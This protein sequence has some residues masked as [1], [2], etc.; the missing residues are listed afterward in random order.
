VLLLGAI[1][2]AVFVVPG[3]WGIAAVVVAVAYEL[4][5]KVFWFRYSQRE[6]IAVGAEA[7]IGA[8]ARV[9]SDCAPRGLVR[10]RG[11]L[12]RAR[13]AERAF[14]CERVRIGSVGRDL[15]LEVAPER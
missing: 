10:F 3:W 7:M 13:C 4:A 2:L 6:P 11:E 12:W 14:A 5:E 1:L 9:V 8:R 15:T